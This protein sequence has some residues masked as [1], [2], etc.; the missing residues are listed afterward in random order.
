MEETQEMKRQL[1]T[2]K[3]VERAKGILQY[4]YKLTEEEAYLRLRNESRR[5]RRPMRDLAEAIILAEDLSRNRSRG[6]RRTDEDIDARYD[7]GL[8]PF[9]PLIRNP[10]LLTIAGNFVK[11]R[12]R[13]VDE[14]PIEEQ[15]I[16]TEPGMRILVHSQR[17][18]GKPKGELMMVHGLEGSSNA[19][20][21]RSLAQLALR[22]VTPR[23]GRTCAACGG[24][25][26]HCRTMYHA[27][28]TSDTLAIVRRVRRRRSPFFSGGYLAWR[29][30]VL[31]LAGELGEEARDLAARQSSRSPLQSTLLHVCGA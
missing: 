25:D 19:G 28:L 27:G 15:L 31:K 7:G 29:K 17:P 3:L 22:T 11:R 21:L 14:F 16:E 10:H 9:H 4:K 24:T 12:P 20:Y 6:R 13:Y 26:E 23:T 30:R 1:E 18:R 8:Q 2:R 5:L